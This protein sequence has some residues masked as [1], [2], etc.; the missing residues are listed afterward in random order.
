VCSS[1]PINDGLDSF[2]AT[3]QAKFEVA[4]SDTFKKIVS[5]VPT[6]EGMNN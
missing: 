3:F 1:N 4:D 5:S 2:R 6:D